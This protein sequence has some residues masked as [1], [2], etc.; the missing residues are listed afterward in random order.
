MSSTPLNS[1]Q[2]KHSVAGDFHANTG[3]GYRSYSKNNMRPLGKGKLNENC[4]DVT[5]RFN[6]IRNK[7]SIT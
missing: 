3:S 2:E 6:Q 5:T 7:S 1:K 4:K